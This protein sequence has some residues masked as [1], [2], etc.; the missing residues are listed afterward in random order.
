MGLFHQYDIRGVYGIELT[1]KFAYDLGKVIVDYTKAKKIIV[2]YDSRNGNLK[3]F[4]A[5]SKAIVEQ[6]KDVIHAGLV[7]RPMLNWVAWSHGYDLAVCI[8]ASHNPKEYNGFKFV[9]KGKPLSYDVGLGDVEE[10]MKKGHKYKKSAKAGKII[11][12]DYI[13][14]YVK[15]LSDNL[16]KDF[17][18]YIKNNNIRIVGDAANGSAGEVMKRFLLVNNITFELLFA[19]PDGTF[20]GHN[21]NPLDPNAMI[22]LSKAVKEFKADFGFMVDPDADRIR[23]VD[24]K[25]MIV[26][27]NFM[28]CLVIEDILKKH[29][30][31]AIVHDLIARKMLSETIRAGHGKNIMSKVGSSNIAQNMFKEKAVFGCE[32]SGHRFFSNMNNLDS[33]MMM[34]VYVLNTLYSTDKAGKRL[35]LLWK[36]YD[37]YPDMGEMNYKLAEGKD[38]QAVMDDIQKY[39]SDNKKKLGV[40]DIFNLDGVSV[41]S[42]K[43]WFNVRPSNTEPL[44]RLRIEGKD[45]NSIV[46]L[47]AQL[48]KFI[49]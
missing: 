23:F 34:L 21:P 40:K 27:N 9:W 45:K 11:S 33:G 8:S 30:G 32:V 3:L 43:Y 19:D 41:I 13:D 38:K 48:E 16:S 44:L 29:K 39:F 15:F 5:F 35:S 24:D 49:L 7:T 18:K 22:I 17:K 37:K 47:K 14:E 36:K 46:K 4:S 12:I 1:E 26:D 20:Y 10:L 31:A 25:G 2:G 28:D 42:D 6:G